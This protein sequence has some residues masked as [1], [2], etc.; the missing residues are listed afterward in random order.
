[1]RSVSLY[2]WS[3]SF[4]VTEAL[5]YAEHRGIDDP[6]QAY[7]LGELI[8]YLCHESSGVLGFN[9]MPSS[10]KQLCDDIQQGARLSKTSD[11]VTECVR[12]W[13]ELTRSM[14]LSLSMALGRSV[15]VYLSAS[16]QKNSDKRLDDDVSGLI[17]DERLSAIFSVPDAASRIDYVADVARRTVTASMTLQAPS[18][19]SRAQS[20]VTWIIKQLDKSTDENV[21][22]VADWPGRSADT[23]APLGKLREA[24]EMLVDGR[25][26]VLPRAFHLRHVVD[27]GGRFKGTKKFVE[28]ASQALPDFY[29]NVGQH[30]KVW[31]P[32]PPPLTERKNVDSNKGNP[33]PNASPP[34]LEQKAKRFHLF[35]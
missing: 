35:G 21:F 12:N 24:P 31:V 29:E 1:M 34:K 7:I 30:L 17:S 10:W 27:L 28:E 22:V 18:D 15:S 9:R 25:K 32:K 19:R 23:M 26:G 33:K 3:W 11:H 2:H 4:I 6:D 5:L 14:A 13:H 20:T 8:R 16:H